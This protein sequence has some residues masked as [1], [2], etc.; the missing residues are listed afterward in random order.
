MTDSIQIPLCRDQVSRAHSALV[1]TAIRLAECMGLHR[2]GTTFGM[3]A[4]ETHV[5]RMIWYQILFLDVRTCEAQG[6]RPGMRDSDFDTKFPLNVDDNELESLTPPKEDAQCWTDMTFTLIRMECNE[7]MRT[8]WFDR[9]RVEARKLALTA[10]LGKIENF[11]RMLYS[12]YGPLLDTTEPIHQVASL[13]MSVLCNRMMIMVLHRYHNGV[14]ARIPDRLRQMI[15][16]SGT[17]QIE[18]SMRMETLPALRTWAWYSGALQQY[19]TAFLL[20]TELFTYPNRR[21]ADRIWKVLDYVFEIPSELSR[22][23]KARL[24]LVEIRDKMDA[25]STVRK[26][27]TP[28]SMTRSLENGAPRSKRDVAN[29]DPLG[30]PLT[31]RELALNPDVQPTIGNAQIPMEVNDEP[32][33]LQERLYLPLPSNESHRSLLRAVS[34]TDAPSPSQGSMNGATISSEAASTLVDEMM[35]DIDWVSI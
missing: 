31:A 20:L 18:A 28:T 35:A 2:D 14:L 11:R 34:P 10:L 5:R 32:A 16:T 23:E 15:L 29:N 19:Q 9:P 6:P 7:M 13:V 3:N 1:G 30:L 27:K 25:Y 12:K 22:D 4:V 33:S 17:T 26:L 8:V 24:I 21:E